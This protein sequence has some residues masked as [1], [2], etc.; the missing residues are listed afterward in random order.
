M[1]RRAELAAVKKMMSNSRLV[2]LTGSGGIGKTRL[3]LRTAL[4]SRRAF[5]DG[6]WL[7]ELGELR[8]E[9]LVAST[10]SAALGMHNHTAAESRRALIDYLSDK[11][12][13]LILDNCEHLVAEVADVVAALLR[14]CPGLRI[15]ATS[16]EPLLIGGEVVS[17]VP[18]MTVP[19]S[20]RELPLN[21]VTE[22]EAVNLFVERATAAAPSFELTAT[23]QRAVT[24]ICQRL[25]GLP[26]PIELAAVRLRA[27]S[28]QQILDRLTDRYRMLTA[29]NRTAPSRQQTLRMCVEWSYDLCSAQEQILWMRLSVFAGTFELD[30]AES[31]CSGEGLD[32]LAELVT[33]LVDK[34]ILIRDDVDSAPRYRVL[35]TI[36]EYGRQKLTANGTEEVLRR[37]HTEWYENLIL[38][39]ERDWISPRQLDWISRLDREQ[40]N[41]REVFQRYLDQP[42]GHD[43]AVRIVEALLTVW[44]S[45]GVFLTEARIWL[46][47]ILSRSGGPA[48]DRARALYLSSVFAVVQ[49]DKIESA[50]LLAQGE[51][52]GAHL[53]N[54]ASSAFAH[55]AAGCH[56]LYN[57]DPARAAALFEDAISQAVESNNSFCH[58]ASLTGL[59]LAHLQLDHVSETRRCYE[60]IIVES[61]KSGEAIFRG[62]AAVI[63]GWALWRDGSL[64]QATSVLEEGVRFSHRVGDRIAVARCFEVLGRVEA[65]QHHAERAVVLSGAAGSI[66]RGVGGPS[67]NSISGSDDRRRSELWGHDALGQRGYEK[68][69][70]YGRALAYEDAVS[71]GLGEPASARTP[72][73][74]KSTLTRRE[75]EVASL[76]A[77]GLTNKGI[78]DRLVISPRTAQ[79]HV[80]HVLVKLGFTSRAQIAAW[81]SS[82]QPNEN[83]A[84]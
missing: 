8:D 78:A 40:P 79:G 5:A 14:T 15:L 71:Y 81:V 20:D 22:Y 77:E 28:P 66:W 57:S 6:V 43:H 50:D 72:S 80:E 73:T 35:E 48:V 32:A 60:A 67:T 18:P 76:V 58:L 53:Q 45:R 17:R 23:N 62:R 34:S 12:L 26:L 19:D 54:T 39:A 31:I 11:H 56:H 82:R 44:V 33:S 69:F 83:P 10:V 16:R 3:A 70:Q 59:G 75:R 4:E 41:T 49:G 25:D 36:R 46:A 2:T 64:A 61:E 55:W 42:Q 13:L 52:I 27:M 74:N 38:Q 51:S 63:G 7:V 47:R 9:A 29:G 1:G 30:A 37:R 84:P 21:T 24:L 65:D 68:H